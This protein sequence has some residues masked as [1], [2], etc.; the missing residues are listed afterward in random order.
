M[1]AAAWDLQRAAHA[2]LAA[3]DTLLT[4]LGGARIYDDVPQGAAFPYVALAGFTARDWAT[5][6]EPG[7]EIVFTVNAW[8]RSAGHKEAHLIADAVRAVLHDAALSLTGHHLVN[9]RHEISETR[10]ERDGDTYRI[11]SRF[12]AVLEPTE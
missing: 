7:V 4:L 12:R 8:S 6:T 9:L 2:A 10:R 3:D 5:G 1:S 11:A